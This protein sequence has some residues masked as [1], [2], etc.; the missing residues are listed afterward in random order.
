MNLLFKLHFLN[1][2]IILSK[3]TDRGVNATFLGVSVTLSSAIFCT[4]FSSSYGCFISQ[5]RNQPLRILII[6]PSPHA[7]SRFQFRIAYYKYL[8]QTL[9]RYISHLCFTFNLI[10]RGSFLN[11]Y[12]KLFFNFNFKSYSKN[13]NLYVDM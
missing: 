3:K 10:I 5:I 13:L 9:N 6:N 12:P 1:V 8:I 11:S 4:K 2:N 7:I